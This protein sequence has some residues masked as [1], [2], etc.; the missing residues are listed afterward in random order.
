MSPS[1]LPLELH[2]GLCSY[3]NWELSSKSVL[4]P[5]AV[6]RP[7]IRAPYDSGD[8]Y[9]PTDELSEFKVNLVYSRATRSI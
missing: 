3:C 2:L 1:R 9:C 8:F 7:M 6:W 4:L 5:E